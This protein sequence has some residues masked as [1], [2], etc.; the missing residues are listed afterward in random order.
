MLYL[1]YR[2]YLGVS[3]VVQM[4]AAKSYNDNYIGIEAVFFQWTNF[5]VN[6]LLFQQSR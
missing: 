6:I 1:T 4:L 3:R 2:G 5:Q